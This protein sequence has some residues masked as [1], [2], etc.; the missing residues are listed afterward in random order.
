MNSLYVTLIHVTLY[1][2]LAG[3]VIKGSI[4]RKG[5]EEEANADLGRAE[6]KDGFCACGKDKKQEVTGWGTGFPCDSY[7]LVA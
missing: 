5:M 4:Q 3:K 7:Y 1:E 6:G 2:A